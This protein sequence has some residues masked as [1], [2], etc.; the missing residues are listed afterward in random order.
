[1]IHNVDSNRVE[2]YN[3]IVAKF[4]G[5]K[6]VNY[7][8]KDN[9]ET[10]CIG[11]AISYNSH[12]LHYSVHKKL[13]NSSPNKFI[14]D[15]EKR[16]AHKNSRSHECLAAN[17]TEHQARLAKRRNLRAA[18]GADDD[19]GLIDNMTPMD[20]AERRT[21]FLQDLKLSNEQSKQA[22]RPGTWKGGNG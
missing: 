9:Y 1:M 15:L 21:Q 17:A 4:V 22:M 11:A 8:I 19:Y 13:Y 5:G 12:H 6:R 10:R 3:A 16:R 2:H 18:A 7:A 20:G 14:K